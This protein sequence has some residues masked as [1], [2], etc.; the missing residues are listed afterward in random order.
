[1]P[2]SPSRVLAI[3]RWASPAQTSPSG[4]TTST[5]S[6]MASPR[7]TPARPSPRA[8]PSRPLQLL[9]LLLHVLDSAA[10]EERLLG[11]VVVLAFGERLEGGDG[12]LQRDGHARLAGELLRHEHGMGQESLDPPCALDGDLIFL[13]QLVDAEDG[14]DVL[15]L[16]VPLQDPLYLA[17]HVV[18]L[19]AHV[20][21]VQN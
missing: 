1:M 19:L 16:L 5:R 21:G 3:T 7:A 8:T 17:G 11:K 13:G 2:I 20:G 10:H 4:A 15:Q 18:M 12:L 14:D 9:G 6:V